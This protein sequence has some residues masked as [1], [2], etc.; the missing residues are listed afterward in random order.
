M[1]CEQLGVS[2]EQLPTGFEQRSLSQARGTHPHN[3]LQVSGLTLKYVGP[4]SVDSHAAAIRA[5][6][7]V[8]AGIPIFFF[9]VRIISKGEEGFIGIGLCRQD[10][11]LGRLPGWEP[12]SYGYHGDDGH[13]FQGSG[14]G[15]QYG[16]RFTTGD[17]VGCLFDQVNRRVVYYKNGREVGVAF[18]DVPEQYLYPV[19]GL[20]TRGEEVEANFG[21]RPFVTDLTPAIEELRYEVMS[22]VL[23]EPLPQRAPDAARH[24]EGGAL[25]TPVRLV[26]DFLVH[27]GYWNTA[28]TLA[29]CAG[30]PK[31]AEDVRY[32]A[33]DLQKRRAMCQ[34]VLQGRAGEALARVRASI[35]DV[36]E[37]DADLKV[38]LYVQCFLELVREGRRD[39]AVDFAQREWAQAGVFGGGSMDLVEDAVA[40]VAYDDPAT[41]PTGHLLR[42]TQREEVAHALD[43]AVLRALG[44]PR[45]PALERALRQL[46]VVRKQGLSI[47]SCAM[48]LLD[49]D[50][51]LKDAPAPGA[52]EVA[53]LGG[54]DGGGE[55]GG[56]DV[57]MRGAEE[58]AG[59]GSARETEED[60]ENRLDRDLRRL[61]DVTEDDDEE[62]ESVPSFDEDQD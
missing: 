46:C 35:P 53:G 27:S 31:L 54:G 47:G 48:G 12:H 50:G 45:R 17:V 36:L 40:L 16:P 60:R 49:P 21:A 22:R 5:N 4:G 56:G 43:N 24:E 23:A 20:R 32:G 55:K 7:P 6:K 57:A 10:V 61:Y 38:R 58:G 19:I 44:R 34:D 37:K 59:G 52:R 15:R 26:L 41:S 1:W 42:Q 28:E 13:T 39:E 14:K 18:E 3:Y 25:P 29:Q 62:M 9:E 30:A 11:P 33:Q 8:P 51:I 2:A